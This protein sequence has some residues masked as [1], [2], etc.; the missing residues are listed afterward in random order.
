MTLSLPS[1]PSP[2]RR[3]LL[4]SAFGLAWGAAVFVARPTSADPL[5]TWPIRI[6]GHE[7]A[8][9]LADTPEARRAGLMFRRSLDEHRGMLFTYDTPGLHAMWMKN[10][11]IPLSVAFIDADARIINIEDMEPQTETA[12]AARAPAS[13]SLEVNRGWFRRRGIRPGDRIEGLDALPLNR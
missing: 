2:S 6:R 7:L 12:H 10:T 13:W 4:R 8:V 11:L 1:R 9:E 3:R 5:R